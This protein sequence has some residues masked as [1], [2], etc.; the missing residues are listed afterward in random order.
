MNKF[1]KYL[2]GIFIISIAVTFALLLIY[3]FFYLIFLKGNE[4]TISLKDKYSDLGR[5][6]VY[7][8]GDVFFFL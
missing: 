7:K 5:Q 8:D 6:S 3:Q 1:S 2:F 4:T